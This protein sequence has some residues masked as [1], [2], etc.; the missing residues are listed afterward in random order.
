M[1]NEALPIKRTA[2]FLSLH[3]HHRE[4]KRHRWTCCIISAHDWSK[5]SIWI[6]MEISSL[7][8]QTHLWNQARP[9]ETYDQ[10]RCRIKFPIWTSEVAQMK[11]PED[12]WAQWIQNSWTHFMLFEVSASR[13]QPKPEDIPLQMSGSRNV[14]D[15]LCAGRHVTHVKWATNGDIFYTMWLLSSRQVKSFWNTSSIWVIYVPPASRNHQKHLTSL[16]EVQCCSHL[17][18]EIHPALQNI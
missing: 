13:R 11:S 16:S 7:L 17:S 18:C 8:P 4:W 10:T 1:S 9:Y 2:K 15:W 6:V 3:H 14:P 5:Q 12:E